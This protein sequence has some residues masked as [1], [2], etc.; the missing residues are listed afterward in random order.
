MFRREQNLE[1]LLVLSKSAV[2][3]NWLVAA[4]N[5]PLWWSLRRFLSLMKKLVERGYCSFREQTRSP[6]R[7]ILGSVA[8]GYSGSI[9]GDFVRAAFDV[10][11]RRLFSFLTG[12]AADR[13]TLRRS[14]DTVSLAQ[15]TGR[16]STTRRWE[17]DLAG[18]RHP[19]FS[20]NLF[21]QR[22]W[23]ILVAGLP[24]FSKDVWLGCKL[25]NRTGK[26]KITSS[27]FHFINTKQSRH[28]QVLL[29]ETFSA[30]SF[31]AS[32]QHVSQHLHSLLFLL[33]M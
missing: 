2:G 19:I 10:W 5:S 12:W 11:L 29:T 16:T 23:D 21:K 26:E 14:C 33:D 9:D 7:V 31:W 1:W 25:Q 17:Q 6:R 30:F 4:V 28:H 13:M 20:G 22:A 3:Q 15:S 18:R 8:G 32:H 24:N 27:R